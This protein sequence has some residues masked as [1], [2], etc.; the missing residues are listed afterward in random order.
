MTRLQ[1]MTARVERDVRQRYGAS[2]KVVR[3]HRCGGCGITI[4]EQ[5]ARGAAFTGC[6]LCGSINIEFSVA[7]LP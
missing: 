4:D 5:T 2:V 6:P 7:V 3:D 1:L